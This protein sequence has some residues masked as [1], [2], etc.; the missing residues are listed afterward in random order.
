MNL[1]KTKPP[2]PIK[3]Q[4]N[5]EVKNTTIQ[6]P[7]LK[8]LCGTTSLCSHRT[9][10]DVIK[11]SNFQSDSSHLCKT[12]F[13][14]PIPLAVFRGLLCNENLC[15]HYKS[16]FW[17]IYWSSLYISVSPRLQRVGLNPHAKLVVSLILYIDSVNNCI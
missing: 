4:P 9:F 5:Q 12:H 3:I 16:M 11:T 7:K 8:P 17:C 6:F 13:K 10:P 15:C 1:I 2:T 14:F